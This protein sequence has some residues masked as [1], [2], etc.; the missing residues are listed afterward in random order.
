MTDLL[1][2]ARAVAWRMTKIFYTKPIFFVPS[3]VFPL[4]F[5]VAFGGAL[6]RLAQV[7][8]FDYPPGFTTYVWCFTL[9][10]GGTL[11]GAFV[12]FGLL[13]DFDTGFTRRLLIAAPERRGIVVGIAA[14]ALVRSCVTSVVISVVGFAVGARPASLRDLLFAYALV[15]LL[16]QCAALYAIG[17]AMRVRSVQGGPLIQLPI[18]LAFFLAPVFVP[19]DLLNGWLKTAAEI[20][21]VS[22]VM[23][24]VRDLVA[25]D[26]STM[27]LAFAVGG[28]LFLL[29]AVF[30]VGGLRR[31]ELAGG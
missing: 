29:M 20:N 8:G 5:L 23:I 11:S 14:G 28:A 16:G 30:A 6:Q 13:R 9:L 24:A 12:G 19:L 21:P 15:L 4:M 2:V 25:G 18:F 10:Q 17:V 27:P 26:T 1:H 31:A 7:P 3:L 22:R